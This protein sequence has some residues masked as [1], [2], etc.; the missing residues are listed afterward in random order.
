MIIAISRENKLPWANEA[1]SFCSRI[2]LTREAESHIIVGIPALD[3]QSF[4]LMPN[5]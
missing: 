4:C 1:A 2:C 5:A 3:G